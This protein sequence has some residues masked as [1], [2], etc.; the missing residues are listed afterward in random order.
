MKLDTGLEIEKEIEAAKKRKAREKE[1]T[2]KAEQ[3]K[4]GAPPLTKEQKADNHTE[5]KEKAQKSVRAKLELVTDLIEERYKFYINEVT[6]ELEF[7]DLL[8]PEYGL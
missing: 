1:L 8:Q 7:Y 6:D 3:E 5:K 4:S 2:K